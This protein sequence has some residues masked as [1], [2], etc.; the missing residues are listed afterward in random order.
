MAD[1]LDQY[2]EDNLGIYNHPMHVFINSDESGSPLNLKILTVGSKNPHHVCY[3]TKLQIT[4]LLQV[5]LQATIEYNRIPQFVISD[6]K[7]LNPVLTAGEV[8]GTLYGLSHNGWMDGDLF[9]NGL[10]NIFFFMPKTIT[11]LWMATR[12]ITLQK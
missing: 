5:L 10:K 1:S 8:V 11:Y 12:P 6:C 3:D 2:A 7:I 4:I 9:L